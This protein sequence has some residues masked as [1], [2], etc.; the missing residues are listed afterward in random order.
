MINLTI[1]YSLNKI[2]LHK[3][4]IYRNKHQIYLKKKECEK[5]VSFISNKKFQYLFQLMNIL[6]ISFKLTYFLN[7]YNIN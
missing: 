7:L 2:K 1:K 4:I 6:F 3:I 5:V